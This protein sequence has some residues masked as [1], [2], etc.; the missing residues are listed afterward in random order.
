M[1]VPGRDVDRHSWEMRY[2]ALE[3]ELMTAPAEALPG[4]AELVQEMIDAA[5]LEPWSD[6]AF[7]AS[8]VLG[9]ARELIE[10]EEAG[11]EAPNDD[12]FQAA[13]ELRAL[14]KALVQLA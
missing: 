14:Y 10:L 7:D 4:L 1:S 3:E 12:V 6:S 5:Q 8:V 13:A 9:R 2:A 11:E